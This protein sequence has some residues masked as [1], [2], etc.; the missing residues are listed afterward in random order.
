MRPRSQLAFL[1]G[2]CAWLSIAA[3]LG[4]FLS[5]PSHGA[6]G[7]DPAHSD[8]LRSVAEFVATDAHA[9]L[10]DKGSCQVCRAASQMRSALRGT[11]GHVPPQPLHQ[12]LRPSTA[13][14]PR[15][16][17]GLRAAWPRAPPSR[18]AA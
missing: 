10:H 4:L 16:A 17:P 18:S 5:E 9:P 11:V 2:A 15:S 14:R 3:L 6:V 7:V 1:R 12:G 13:P 8:G